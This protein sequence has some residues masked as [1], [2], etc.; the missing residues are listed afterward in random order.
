M[1]AGI[2]FLVIATSLRSSRRNDTA[3]GGAANVCKK[4]KD[5]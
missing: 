1:A 5:I 4:E 3:L 2:D